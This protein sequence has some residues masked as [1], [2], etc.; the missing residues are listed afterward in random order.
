[1]SSHSENQP[2]QGKAHSWPHAPEHRLAGQGAY[3]VTAGTFRK[4]HFFADGPKLAA[5]HNG[6]LKYAQKYHWRLQAWAVFPNHY[7]FVGTSP[8]DEDNANSLSTFIQELHRKSATWLNKEDEI[9]GRK[10][11]HNYWETHLTFEA[12]YYARLNYVHQ[13]AV[14]HGLTSVASDYPYCSA[15][16][17]EK[18]APKPVQNT[19]ASFKTDQI[20]I[21]DDF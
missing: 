9:S 13:N 3:I 17:F 6:L 15:R 2:S 16:W 4:E 11:W 19:I 12:S 20:K 1:L 8:P 10:V 5:L 18:K 7:H 14:H 21:I